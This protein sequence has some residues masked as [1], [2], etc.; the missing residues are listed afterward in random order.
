MDTHQYI[1]E[2]LTNLVFIQIARKCE[3][4]WRE[5]NR[6]L[7]LN[8]NLNTHT[9]YYDGLAEQP[10]DIRWLR[11]L[12]TSFFLPKS[13]VFAIFFELFNNKQMFLANNMIHQPFKARFKLALPV[14]SSI[15]VPHSQRIVPS[16]GRCTTA[17]S[18]QR[19][20]CSYKVIIR[21]IKLPG[22]LQKKVGGVL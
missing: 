22:N 13:L 18:S 5:L 17:V 8:R 3:N 15:C 12:S 2:C 19:I 10:S 6:D 4:S 20:N 14:M 16:S 11:G 9:Y 21:G 7:N 1:S